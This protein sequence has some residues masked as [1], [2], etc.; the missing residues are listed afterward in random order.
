MMEHRSEFIN[1]KT[2]QYPLVINAGHTQSV[3]QT[4]DIIPASY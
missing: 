3:C 2:A 4:V 1:M